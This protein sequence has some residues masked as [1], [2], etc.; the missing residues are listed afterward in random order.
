MT[1]IYAAL[2]QIASTRRDD[3][4]R[5]VTVIAPSHAAALQLRRRLA[6]LGPFAGIRF[7]TTPRVAELIAGGRLAAAGRAP[8][9]RPIGDYLAEVAARD[10]RGVLKGVADLPGYARTLRRIFG[11]LRR[12]GITSSAEVTVDLLPQAREILRMYDGFRLSAEQFY[13][14]EDLLDAAADACERQLTGVL[15]DVGETFI[16]PPGPQTAA[17][18]ALVAALTRIGRA[19][20]M[21]DEAA[22]NAEQRFVVCPDSWTEAREVARGVVQ[23]LESGIAIDEIGV[24]HGA[25]E[26]YPALLREAFTAARIPVTP[27]PGIP[28][29]EMRAGRGALLLAELPG[30]DYARTAVMEFFSVAPLKRE[31]PTGGD[32]AREN[33][34][35]WDSVSR[36]AGVTRGIEP[37]AARLQRFANGRAAEAERLDP[38]EYDRRIFM[39]NLERAQAE[40]LGAVVAHLASR[41]EPLRQLQPAQSFMLSL[42]AV[43]RDYIDNRAPA[44]DD[45]C[46]EIAQ[47]GTVGAVGGEMSL[48]NFAQALRANL[49]AAYV[50]PEKLGQ[51]VVLADYRQAAGMRFQRVFLCGAYEGALPAGPGADALLDDGSWQVLK[52]QFP[53]TED[54]ETRLLR[55]RLAAARAVAAAGNG[56]LMWSCPAFEPGGTREYYP[57]PAMAEQ[58]GASEGR[59]V[60]SAQLRNGFGRAVRQSSPLGASLAGPVLDRTELA[61]RRAILLGREQRALDPGHERARAVGMLK[62]RRSTDF[63][64]WD[65]N[66][67][68]AVLSAARMSPTRLEEYATCGF[69]YFLAR[70]LYVNVVSEPEQLEMM[71]PAVRGSL[72]HRVL[73]AFF[74]EQK[75]RGRPGPGEAWQEED[76]RRL[77]ELFD[78]AWGDA[79]DKGESGMEIYAEYDRRSAHSDLE[80]F[81][82]EDSQFR[83]KTGCIP[84]EFEV[85]VESDVAGIILRGKADRVDRSPDGSRAWVIDYKTGRADKI[86]DDDP[87]SGGTKLQLPV[88][89]AATDGVPDAVA[90][91]W[92]ITNRGGFAR[93]EY[94]DSPENSARFQRTVRA[95]ADGVA[96]G[97]YPAVSGG[98]D[99]HYGTYANCRICDFG[100]ICSTRRDRDFENKS[101]DPRMRPWLAIGAAATG[102]PS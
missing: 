81:L 62:A 35:A 27:L 43:V 41:L 67:G 70:G 83:S 64:E 53:H 96:A 55:A 4:L 37:W 51:G 89:L 36:E 28:L 20:A 6:H 34:T 11:R 38:G 24:F 46:E 1:D 45:V 82:E 93:P 85:S 30:K 48:G 71:N 25:G 88:Y 23:A 15:P 63:T 19:P 17:G 10:S 39:L 74:L 3:P 5:P 9:A 33:A 66:V 84:S 32:P 100:R 7:E 8:L 54:V 18:H 13:D 21:L 78:E 42:T 73:E 52:K 86:K 102:D 69:K 87:L 49:Q 40:Q 98:E 16:V 75:G 14:V 47:L 56:E 22:G 80:R 68:I 72:I 26:T 77:L 99:E 65:G 50:R 59:R 90:A 76:R 58:I 57:S 60:S 79:R 29:I 97:V 95:I 94:R 61:I 2:D 44:F 91:Y 101:G 92:Y 12:A 31:L